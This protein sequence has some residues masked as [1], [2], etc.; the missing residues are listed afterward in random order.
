MSL[1]SGTRLGSYEIGQPIGAGGMGEVYRA[2]D[3]K[4]QRDV[5]VK[6]LPDIFAADHDRVLGRPEGARTRIEGEGIGQD[7]ADATPPGH[8][9]QDHA[10]VRAERD[11]GRA[12]S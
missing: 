2:R 3:T 6:L 10:A 5:A 12:V 7:G 8:V 11:K 4:L 1:S 9:Q